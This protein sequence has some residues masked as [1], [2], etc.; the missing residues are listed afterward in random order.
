M[1]G[2]VFNSEPGK[3]ARQIICVRANCICSSDHRRL[4]KN[5]LIL[6]LLRGLIAHPFRAY[7]PHLFILKP[8]D[9]QHLLFF[10]SLAI[11]GGSILFFSINSRQSRSTCS[12]TRGSSSTNNSPLPS[13]RAFS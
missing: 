13:A 6:K 1:R 2:A 12:R 3:T 7:L 9:V 5:S 8:F 11:S 4:C 10:F